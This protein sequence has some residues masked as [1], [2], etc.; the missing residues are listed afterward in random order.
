MQREFPVEVRFLGRQEPALEDGWVP[1]FIVDTVPAIR[2]ENSLLNPFYVEEIH[3]L[4]DLY[5]RT[6]KDSASLPGSLPY[7]HISSTSVYPA[8]VE[9]LLSVDELSPTGETESCRK[10]LELEEAILRFR[11][12]AAIVRAGGLY[13]PGRSLP[14]M[15]AQGK[16]RFFE[17]GDDVISRVHVHDLCRLV[18]TLG[19]QIQDG[20]SFPGYQRSN[21]INAVD[22]HPSSVSETRLFLLEMYSEMEMQQG[23][24][25]LGLL[26]PTSLP[27]PAP[28]PGQREVRSI[29]AANLIGDFRFPDYRSG[30]RDS[31]SRR[32]LQ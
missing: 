31:I 21:L 1:D 17:R 27:E 28:V 10:R 29:Y 32:M 18:L 8:S 24:R 3:R 30:F 19:Q 7:I 13:G 20:V 11:P 23:L 4:D 6:A 25:R 16:A 26:A 5:S 22:P 14:I 12:E 15:I 9:G 2:E